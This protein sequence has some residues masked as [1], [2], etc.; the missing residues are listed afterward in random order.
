MLRARRRKRGRVRVVVH[1]QGAS[2]TDARRVSRGAGGARSGPLS[3]GCRAGSEKIAADENFR[4]QD[5]SCSRRHPPPR[6]PALNA[7]NYGASAA[8]PAAIAPVSSHNVSGGGHAPD[9]PCP[10]GAAVRAGV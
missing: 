1:R 7:G 6:E 10:A 5:A 9:G 3:R 8:R 4:L 2:K